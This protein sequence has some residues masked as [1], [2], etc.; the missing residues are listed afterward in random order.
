MANFDSL[1]HEEVLTFEKGKDYKGNMEYIRVSK[2]TN[3]KNGDVSV[4]IRKYYTAENDELKP[5]K[6]GVRFSAENLADVMLALTKCM[7][8]DEVMDF[9]DKVQED[10]DSDLGSDVE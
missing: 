9:I 4:D 10:F 7:E 2:V 8:A 3:T 5:A 6:E 1:K